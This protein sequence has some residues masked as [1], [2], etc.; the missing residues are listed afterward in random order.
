MAL[1]L[2]GGTVLTVDAEDRVLRGVDIRIEAGTIAA[3]GPGL[4]SPGDETLD[5]RRGVVMPG[6]VNVHTHAATALF[7]GLA[8]DLPRDF[9]AG[10]YK[11]P[12]EER[13]G[14]KDYALSLRAACA[15][16]LANGVTCIADR[17]AGMDRLAPVI[18]A[19][20][21]RAVV[22]ST[23]TDRRAEDAWRET[24]ALLDHWGTDPARS[25]VT[26]AIAPHALD[27][28]SDDL[29]RACA[30]RAQASDARVVL[31]VAQSAPEVAAVRARGHAGAL[32]CLR[33]AGLTGPRVVAAHCI[34]LDESEMEGWCADGTAIAHCPASNL[35]IEAR[36]IPLHR[37]AGCVPVGLGTDWT[38]SDNSMDMFWEARLAALVG[39]MNAG[40][41]TALPVRTMLRMLTIE[42]ARVLGLDH[43]V[44][45][46]EPGKRADLIVL[47]R[48]RLEMA[49]A[50]DL[51]A[52]ILYSA[53][54]RSVRDVLV[55]GVVLKRDH[56]LVRDDEAAL[57]AAM[58]AAGWVR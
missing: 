14:P 51:A 31:H 4:A 41:P 40:D 7:R 39:K 56:R 44:G 46:V 3:I 19:S 55:D 21:L 38:A 22:G 28:C 43:L 23:L 8:E 9:W 11:V 53:S 54:P 29:L 52:N 35:K 13:F 10:A 37:Y 48:D 36:T 1:V 45:S 58:D 5:C 2:Q 24:D 30:A 25:R 42:G 49:P 20:G 27:S 12:G 47:D 18:E 26:A 50:H 34:Y 32:A 16:F 33:K 57:V 6:L 17:L 15:E